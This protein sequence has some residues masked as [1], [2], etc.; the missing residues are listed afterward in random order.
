MRPPCAHLL[1]ESRLHGRV[2]VVLL[3]EQLRHHA[4]HLR[5]RPHLVN[6]PL[7]HLHRILWG[8]GIIC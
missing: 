2:I 6:Q 3:E 1:Q 8:S 4:R 5:V 7:F